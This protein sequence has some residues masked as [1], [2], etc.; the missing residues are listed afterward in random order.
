[1]L[2]CIIQN[3]TCTHR[4]LF[5][6]TKAAMFMTWLKTQLA[7]GASPA[8]LKDREIFSKIIKASFLLDGD[9]KPKVLRV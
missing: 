9:P 3:K 2:N 7:G 4:S 1:M 5:L 6:P 8:M